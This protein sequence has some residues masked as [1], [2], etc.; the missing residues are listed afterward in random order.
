MLKSKYTYS[1]WRGRG[2]RRERGGWCTHPHENT[3]TNTVT[4]LVEYCKNIATTNMQTEA[5]DKNS[6]NNNEPNNTLSKAT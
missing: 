5:S 3:D 2:A 6:R 4:C 1:E